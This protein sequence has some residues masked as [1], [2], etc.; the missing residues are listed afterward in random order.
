MRERLLDAVR[1]RLA[2]FATDHHA[3]VVLDDE[4]LAEVEA[5]VAAVHDPARDLDVCY[6]AGMV[7]WY[8]YLLLPVGEDQH[9]LAVAL[10]LLESV[11]R[12]QPAAIPVE[13][14]AYF[15][16]LQ[17][18]SPAIPHD[19]AN[20]SV[21]LLERGLRTGDVV[22]LS[23]AADLLRGALTAF[24]E[25]SFDRAALLSNLG[26]AL[27][28]RFERSG[29]L[30]DL[31]DLDAAID[32]GRA[33]V[34]AA[35][36]GGRDHSA[37][38][39]N[40]GG[41]LR[42]RFERTGV[43]ADLD[44]AVEVGR[45]AV[46]A[47]GPDHPNW[48]GYLSNLGTTLRVRFERTGVLADLD[49]AVEVGRAAVDATALDHPD[50][51]RFLANLGGTLHAR[52]GR[53]GA[54]PD[55]DAAV[56]ASRA[57][58][59][60][61]TADH[62]D[63]AGR[64]AN[65]GEALRIRSSWTGALADLD[66]SVEACQTAVAAAALDDPGRAT[67]LVG[68]GIVLRDRSEQTG[69]LADLNTAVEMCR[70]AV[71]ASTARNAYR[72]AYLSALGSALLLRFQSTGA[73]ADLDAAVEAGREAVA[74][75]APGEPGLAGRLSDL[76]LALR[77]RFER[78]GALTDLE[79]SVEVARAAVAATAAD[80]PG[81]AGMLS[82]LGLALR[83]RF[84]RTGELA[85]L[86][87]AV[88]A[89]KAAVEIVPDHPDRAIYLTNLGLALRV[90]SERTGLLGDLDAAVEMCRAAVAATG[91]GHPRRAGTL[92]NLGLA[93]R[94]RF[95][96]TGE[97]T[98]LDAA[99]EVGQAAA[100]AAGDRPDR[101]GY[102][103]NLGTILLVRF[104]RTRELADLHAAVEAAREAVAASPFD[105]PDTAMYLSNLGMALYT[106]FERTAEPAELNAA[107][108]ACRSAIEAAVPDHP[109][110]AMY[111]A[112]LATFLHVRF[113]RTGDPADLEAA[114]NVSGQATGMEVA[115]PRQRARA[116]RV[117]GS[118]AAAGGRWE[119]AVE[120]FTAALGLQGEVVAR[121]LPR[122][123]REE[124]LAEVG[125]LSADAAVCAV[126]TGDP[127]RALELF[128]QG[129][130][131]LLGQA[132]DTRG[133][134]NDLQARHAELHDRFVALAA[135]LDRPEPAEWGA[136]PG[137][138]ENASRPN[139]V[140]GLVQYRRRLREQF[141]EVVAEIRNRSGFN[142]FLR[143]QSAAE[144]ARAAAGGSVVMVAVSEFGSYALVLTEDGAGEPV[145][146]GD[147]TPQAVFDE[148]LAFMTAVE[149][150]SSQRTTK[151][152]KDQ[153]QDRLSTTLG[154][155]WD[156]LA[157]PVLRQ[158]DRHGLLAA[159]LTEGALPRVWWCLSGM[160]SFLPVHAAGRHETRIGA[161]PSTV[162]DQV[163]SSYT[164][165]LRALAH[166]RR[167]ASVEHADA[168]GRR[169]VAVVMPRTP[170]PPGNP[171]DDAS[172]DL[173]GAEAELA[174]LRRYLPG[175]VTALLGEQARWKTVHAALPAGRWAHFACHGSSDLANPSTSRLLLHDHRDR[176]FTVVDVARLRLDAE[177]AYL[178][179]CS[180][181]RPGGRLPDEAIHLASAFQLAGYRHVIATLW[182]INDGVAVGL[183]DD[184]YKALTARIPVDPATALHA[185][186]R[187]LRD[188]AS[189]RPSLWAS[190]I[191]TGP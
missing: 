14:R 115:S 75:T 130:G 170:A 9:D 70:E 172:L 145:D 146:L 108:D 81:R 57:A 38:L 41:A 191:H 154:W 6:S 95:G 125:G 31:A 120:G 89:G 119:A 127:D 175:R 36:A 65:L 52:F 26:V 32:A 187:R 12:A 160:L 121:E 28:A 161:H 77:A 174:T 167:L 156:R 82:N 114:M 44:T 103:S 163:V 90:R 47:T 49:T 92:S 84:G 17:R 144:L 3:S 69:A 139:G 50:H 97:P 189:A 101:A 131:V 151:D 152:E 148:V 100:D 135:E 104:D 78:T 110:Q 29:A 169:M 186:T 185:A 136:L 105:H 8:R 27:K 94:I 25:G 62:P 55:L 118:A 15:H 113:Q 122:A 30:A 59:E 159:S 53:T 40:L 153:A 98:D 184:V 133:D 61:T 60:V 46:D 73:L 99:V 182:P 157:S 176:S 56:D 188:L 83:V 106:R 165:T 178:S 37:Y 51:A 112:N 54:L 18:V 4:A 140:G 128:E 35:V 183:A 141:D 102:L 39:V 87:A 123:D 63:Y 111:L 137:A 179:A 67:Y 80:E 76:G 68:L 1:A 48:G 155:L 124:L 138:G 96:R 177:L 107:V 72:G 143:P 43:L 166:A 20:Q 10:R 171:G 162:I 58:V 74:A 21:E 149:T 71:A 158:M 33:A 142:G 109:E 168:D 173:P 93:L 181:A 126:R 116:A 24:P 16:Q 164:P 132:L 129:R 23:A 147:L 5:L 19:W 79:A 117:W 180:T 34:D 88:E 190:H 64:L 42:V 2:R 7:H 22:A 45:A 11:H 85:D 134:L 91:A 13:A 150:L 86:D 66:A